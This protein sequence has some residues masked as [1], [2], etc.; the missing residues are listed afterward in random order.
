MDFFLGQNG[1][2][3]LCGGRGK[4]FL[5]KMKRLNFFSLFNISSADG[6][7]FLARVFNLRTYIF[8]LLHSALER[9]LHL[10]LVTRAIHFPAVALF[11]RLHFINIVSHLVRTT[12]ALWYFSFA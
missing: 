6:S 1:R 2:C 10:L 3:K 8:T 7:A 11:G 9:P 4:V 5:E 12:F